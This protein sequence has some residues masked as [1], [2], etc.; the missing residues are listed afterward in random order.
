MNKKTKVVI[1]IAVVIIVCIVIFYFY[2]KDEYKEPEE[3]SYDKY[4]YENRE[5]VNLE[6]GKYVESKDYV[7]KNGD[8]LV[9]VSN[10]NDYAAQARIY[11]EFFDEKE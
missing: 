4:Y 3:T 1:S 11:I 8:I 5:K 9:E 10:K 2:S 7:L 6:M